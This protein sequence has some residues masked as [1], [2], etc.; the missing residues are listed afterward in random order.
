[1][2]SPVGCVTPADRIL[3]ESRSRGG[4]DWTRAAAA[5]YIL[6]WLW[7]LRREDR[8]V[9]GDSVMGLFRRY[10]RKL[11]ADPGELIRWHKPA[12]YTVGGGWVAGVLF[13]TNRRVCFVPGSRRYETASFPLSAL[14]NVDAMDRTFT[15]FDGGMNRRLRLEMVDGSEH[16]FTIG[17]VDESVSA[18]RSL[19][20]NQTSPPA[21]GSDWPPAPWE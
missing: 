15:P 3:G 9:S 10:E 7:G 2:A 20:V 18:V 5:V 4:S 21:K 17:H 14:A 6:S 13:V 1:M 12:S 16:F 8:S 19:V 11:D